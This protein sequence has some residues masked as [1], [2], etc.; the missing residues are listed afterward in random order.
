[1]E[2]ADAFRCIISWLMQ[3]HF[4]LGQHTIGQGSPVFVIAEIGINHGGSVDLAHKM[5]DGAADAGADAVKFQT[6][7]A[8]ASYVPG[9]PSYPVFADAALTFE[10][11]EQLMAHCE[12]RGVFFF[13]TPGDW[14]SLEM[15]AR[16]SIPAI[17]ISSG[18]MT[19]LPLVLA[20]ARMNV[21]LIISTGGTYLSE[22]TQLVEHLESAGAT[23]FALLHCVSV[24][25]AADDI[26]NLGAIR[27]L[28]D[29]F[30]YP[31]GY[32][33]HSMGSVACVSAVALGACVLEKHFSLSRDLPGGD[34]FLS[35]EP[36]EF[37]A[38]VADVRAAE[39]M[40][41]GDGKTPNE[42]ELNF[43]K[44]MRRRLVATA[45]IATGD[46]LTAAVV[47]LMRPLE[48]KGL[49]PEHYEAVLGMKAARD[50]RR[51]EPIDW[52]AITAE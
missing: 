46:L 28:Q 42:Q 52:D 20:S 49:A 21:P 44:R 24:Y 34:N 12:E 2:A 18:L 40:L 48:P 1:M 4:N 39:Q 7:D 11:Y 50:I 47:G 51:H 29:L 17:K 6:T 25:P 27:S 32:S 31:I 19:N 45:D 15:C 14:P 10:E 23:E 43:R 35:A 37:A 3:R 41:I 8:D 9:T 30:S 13:T 36:D 16:L 5:I 33:D 22:V 38:L 26:L